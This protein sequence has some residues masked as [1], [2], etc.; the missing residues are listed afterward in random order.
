MMLDSM[1]HGSN[2][3]NEIYPD[4]MATNVLLLLLCFLS[5]KKKKN[6]MNI[7]PAICESFN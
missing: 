6:K 5:T 4:E 2:V 7:C 3:H 1:N